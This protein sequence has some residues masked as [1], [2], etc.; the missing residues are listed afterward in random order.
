MTC[1]GAIADVETFTKVSATENALIDAIINR[2]AF[3]LLSFT[4]RLERIIQAGSGV[5]PYVKIQLGEPI[6]GN[7]QHR[8]AVSYPHF[9][10]GRDE[11][12]IHVI[13]IITAQPGKREELLKA[14]TGILSE[15]HTETG[16]IEYQPV[17]DSDESGSQSKLG[18]DTYMVIEKW[19]CIEDLR[20][21][22]ASKHMTKYSEQTGHLVADRKVYVL[23]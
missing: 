5:R 1:D 15:V 20:A 17:V 13:A 4:Q 12:M 11:C 6:Y 10:L 16:C 23:N 18:S 19:Q 9:N 3:I 2:I 22:A 14:F 21:H 8:F 7:A